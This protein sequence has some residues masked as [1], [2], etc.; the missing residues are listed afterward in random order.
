LTVVSEFAE[1]YTADAEFTHIGMGSAAD[2]AAVISTSGELRLS[3][4]FNFE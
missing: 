4:L 2:F 1:T 3:L